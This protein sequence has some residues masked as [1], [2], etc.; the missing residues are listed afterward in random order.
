MHATFFNPGLPVSVIRV[1]LIATM[2][3]LLSGWTCGA[4]F[5]SCQGIGSPQVT[6]LSPG[7]ISSNA[8]PVLMAVEGTNFSPQSQ[9]MWDG[10][11][12]QTT[13]MDAR[14]LHT[15][16][17]HQTLDSLG[18]SPGTRVQISVKSQG[19]GDLG[20]PIGGDSAALVLVVN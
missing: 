14:H 11:A 3:L 8:E 18:A 4:L 5:V 15:V 2:T 9:I 16:I 10:Q 12:L 19:S 17:T 13:F 7:S 1:A 6:S 20:C